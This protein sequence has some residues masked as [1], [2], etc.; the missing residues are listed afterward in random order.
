MNK[1][2]KQRVFFGV[3]FLILVLMSS[4]PPRVLPS[5]VYYMSINYEFGFEEAILSL[6]DDD[7]QS[8]YLSFHSR[9]KSHI[10]WGWYE[11]RE[12]TLDLHPCGYSERLWDHFST[13]IDGNDE[14]G[15]DYLLPASFVPASDSL[16]KALPPESD[17]PFLQFFGW[18][19]A[20][21]DGLKRVYSK[22]LDCCENMSDQVFD[23][24]T[25]T[26]PKCSMDDRREY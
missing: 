22:H 7:V 18:P 13:S 9:E 10:I 1:R 12:D 15:Q 23:L 5:A 2:R 20:Y 25:A 24:K 21:Y 8:Y 6:M 14:K 4:T 19:F 3:L 17:D 11:Y 26:N 16:I